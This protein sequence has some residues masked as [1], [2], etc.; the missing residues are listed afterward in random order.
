MRTAHCIAFI[1]LSC[2]ATAC[3]GT[4]AP[5]NAA[6]SASSDSALR[7]ELRQAGRDST[8]PGRSQESSGGSVALAP[9]PIT[10]PLPGAESGCASEALSEQ[11]RCLMAHIARS[12]A[13]LGRAYQAVIEEMK[14]Q[15][16]PAADGRE[17]QVVRELRAQEREWLDYRDAQCRRR[18]RD[19]EGPLWAPVRAACLGE[20][21]AHR[22]GQLLA[23]LAKMRGR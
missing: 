19:S 1:A 6:A 22:E 7:A 11:R 14:R 10:A 9:L 5:A 8:R 4:D 20:F 15:S 17:P 18:T 21:S 13:G 2:V 3:R 12:D 16:P 23:A